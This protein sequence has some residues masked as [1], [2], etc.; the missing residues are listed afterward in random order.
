MISGHYLYFL[1]ALTFFLAL[2]YVFMSSLLFLRML[3]YF[4]TKR[5]NKFESFWQDDILEYVTSKAD[6]QTIISKI[7]R[8]YYPNLITFLSAFFLHL[9][10]EDLEQLK[11]LITESHLKAFF[12]KNLK[13]FRKKKRI[14]ATYFLRYIKSDDVVS[15]LSYELNESNET[16]F[17][18]AV[19]SLAYL[20]EVS[21]VNQILDAAKSRKQFTSDSILSMLIKFD[22]SICEPLSKRLAVEKD[23]EIQQIIITILWH[24]KYAA[25]LDTVLKILMYSGAKS[26]IL[27]SIK[28]I[29]EIEN[30]DSVHSL[31][32]FINHSRAD[33]RAAA[34]RAISKI[35][36]TTNEDKI[37]K[38][39]ND[40]DIEVKIA[41]AN[42][43]YNG[44]KEAKAKLFELAWHSPD[45]I[46]STVA[47]RIILEKRIL[48]NA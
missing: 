29:G 43:M 27:E 32:F 3:H 34:I 22:S 18:T 31:R 4:G 26:L 8:S 10:G 12:M 6:P 41:A 40:E 33:I 23:F 9:K 7:P 20:C 1:I 21:L 13:S 25:A 11:K 39:I 42:A 24:F 5:Q 35:G 16:I 47:N 38:R 36:D 19:E 28:Y 46:V 14:E 2:T 37:I 45:K 44:S 15:L 17:R 30:I 48:E